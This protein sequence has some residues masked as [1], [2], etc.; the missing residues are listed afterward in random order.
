MCGMAIFT[1][2]LGAN[3]SLQ[4]ITT[5]FFLNKCTNK[6]ELKIGM[7]TKNEEALL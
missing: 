4:P 2:L 7:T 5:A 1:E 3:Y 6:N